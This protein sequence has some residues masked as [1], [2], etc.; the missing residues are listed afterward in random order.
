VIHFVLFVACFTVL[1][2]VGEERVSA[3]SRAIVY[4]L[5]Q[6]IK[7]LTVQLNDRAAPAKVV[8]NLCRREAVAIALFDVSS[9]RFQDSLCPDVPEH[10][11]QNCCREPVSDSRITRARGGVCL[12]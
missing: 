4:V 1:V 8:Q 7:Y 10:A 11:V 12:V 2:Q 6:F 5:K 3:C 9:G